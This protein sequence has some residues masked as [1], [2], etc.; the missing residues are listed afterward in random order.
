MKKRIRFPFIFQHDSMQC[1]V[2]CL[3]MICKYYDRNYS[4]DMLFNYCAENG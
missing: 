1:G 2:T 3:Q 4:I